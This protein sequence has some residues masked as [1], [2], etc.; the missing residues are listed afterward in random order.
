MQQHLTQFKAGLIAL[1]LLPAGITFAATPPVSHASD[2]A[3]QLTGWL[4]V[5]DYTMEDV[6]VQVDVDGVTHTETVTENGR[7]MLTLPANAEVTLR[8]EKPGHLS[9]EVKVDTRNVRDGGFGQHKKRKVSFAVIMQLERRMGGLT[10]PGPVG[11]LGFEQGGGCLA[12]THDRT[13]IPASQAPMI[14]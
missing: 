9:K 10:Y 14:F 12:V 4:H 3:V 2:Q 11:S 1:F 7:F 5:E 13:L 6:T 8:F